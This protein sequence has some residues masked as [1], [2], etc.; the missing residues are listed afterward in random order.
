MLKGKLET[1]ISKIENGTLRE[2]EGEY[3]I[4]GLS[5]LWKVG[6]DGKIIGHDIYRMMDVVEIEYAGFFTREEVIALFEAYID[7]E[8]QEKKD[9]VMKRK[10]TIKRKKSNRR[11]K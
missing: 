11:R 1:L 7:E 4:K 10:R 3:W 5:Y 6:N 8:E 2:K 9:A